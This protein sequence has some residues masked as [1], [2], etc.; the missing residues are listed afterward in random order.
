LWIP[1]GA[2]D[3]S[4]EAFKDG[5]A[6][7][8]FTVTIGDARDQFAARLRQHFEP[9]GWNPRATEWL[10]PNMPTSFERGWVNGAGGVRPTDGQGKPL[11]LVQVY[12][13]T[14]EW[15]S[16]EG[17]VVTYNLMTQNA[18]VRVSAAYLPI[19][20]IRSARQARTN[21]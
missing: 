21:R 8:G 16:A 4:R 12:L 17:D 20:V 19:R 10:N 13:W 14:G 2:I 11:P 5:S 18:S 15:E 9:N 6:V 7:A 3:I 1:D